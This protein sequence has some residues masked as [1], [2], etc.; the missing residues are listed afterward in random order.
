MVNKYSW[1]DT[2][3]LE[4]NMLSFCCCCCFKE[5]S[6]LLSC[7]FVL[8]CFIFRIWSG[9]HTAHANHRLTPWFFCF[10]IKS[11]KIIGVSQNVWPSR[12]FLSFFLPFS[13]SLPCHL[14]VSVTICLFHAQH[15]LKDSLHT[16]R[17]PSEKRA[18]SIFKPSS[19]CQVLNL[20]GFRHVRKWI[21][22]IW[23]I[24]PVVLHYGTLVL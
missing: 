7:L 13:T 16:A 8:F 10:H 24:Q 18:R 21:L 15:C 17:G 2:S 9:S 11:N 5:D 19:R 20:L 1:R 4:A 23:S 12:I 6:F 14:S 3:I 22:V